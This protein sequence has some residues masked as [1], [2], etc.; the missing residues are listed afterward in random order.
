MARL[1]EQPDLIAPAVEELL[2]FDGPSGA[3]VRLVSQAFELHGKPLAA[4]DRIFL[5]LNSANR[6]QRAYDRA[7][8]LLLDRAG[9][10]H[11]TFGFG[12]HMCMGFPLART[13]G[14][15]AFPKVLSAFSE[16]ETV[17]EQ[18]WINSMVFRGMHSLNVRVRHA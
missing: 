18:T 2:R 15:V 12:T 14:Q 6:D 1:R 13:E 17:G 9:P 4:G 3:Q 16:I 5:M 11:L 7:D 8:Q 10:T